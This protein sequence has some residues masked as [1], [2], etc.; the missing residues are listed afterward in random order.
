M[1]DFNSRYPITVWGF[2]FKKP[3]RDKIIVFARRERSLHRQVV[4]TF[5]YD[6]WYEI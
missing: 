6:H 5:K 1:R 3:S 2:A 4:K